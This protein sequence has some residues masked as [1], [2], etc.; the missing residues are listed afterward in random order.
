MNR[1]GS[2]RI[3]S[4]SVFIQNLLQDH[5]CGLVEIV[6]LVSHPVDIPENVEPLQKINDQIGNL[7]FIVFE[8]S[9]RIFDD[10]ESLDNH[11]QKIPVIGDLHFRMDHALLLLHI[12]KRI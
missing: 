1:D 12:H 9:G 7:T 4:L 11:P 10:F 3:G 5:H 2:H 8:I 6:C